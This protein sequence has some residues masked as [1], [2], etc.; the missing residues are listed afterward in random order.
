MQSEIKNI[1]IVGGGTAGWLSAGIIAAE[2]LDLSAETHAPNITITVVESANVK[3]LGVGEGTWPSMRSTL[4]KIG[5]TEAELLQKCDVSFKQASKFVNWHTEKN[6]QYYHPFTLPIGVKKVNIA[7]HWLNAQHSSQHDYSQFCQSVGYQDQICDLGLAPKMVATREYDA[8]ANYGYHLDAQKFSQLL[9]EHCTAKLGVKHI[10]NDVETVNVNSNGYI[11]SLQTQ[12]NR[13][14]EGD[15]FIDCS[16]LHALLIGQHYEVPFIEQKSVLFNDRAL[17]VQVPYTDEDE[18]IASYTLSTAQSNGWIWD[19]GLQ[20]RRGIG[21]VYA[22]EYTTEAQAKTTLQKYLIKNTSLKATD[23]LNIKAFEFTP[24]YREHFWHKNCVAVGMSAGFIEPLEAS[25]LALIEQSA[26]VISEQ[27]PRT[28]DSM[29]IIAKRFNQKMT[30][31]WQQI[32]EFLKLHYVLSARKDSPYWLDNRKPESIPPALQEQL[33]LWQHQPPSQYDIAHTEPL[34]PA[35]SYQ[36]ILY[37]MHFKTNANSA[38][39]LTKQA[40][41]ALALM[42]DNQQKRSQISSVLPRNRTLL[43]KINQYGMSNI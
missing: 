10:V 36:Y 28:F 11:K 26:K 17:A 9:K 19:I 25:A 12:Q 22:S 32:I 33:K 14:I 31:H 27:L 24:G 2:H 3:T 7:E 1:V 35:A 16:G 37:G 6:H 41:F 42:A 29:L 5:I 43:N 13:T 40:E 34:F 20:T 4:R 39:K 38:K 8:I 15:L 21:Y 30:K 23:E 18:A